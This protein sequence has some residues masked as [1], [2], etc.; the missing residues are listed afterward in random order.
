MRSLNQQ[1]GGGS[2]NVFFDFSV[3]L[4][5]LMI[6]YCVCSHCWCPVLGSSSHCGSSD[7]VDLHH[8][9]RNHDDDD[10]DGDERICRS[11]LHLAIDD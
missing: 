10:D 11:K 1:A 2:L 6:H 8:S 4:M 7:D 3:A 9:Q 5:L